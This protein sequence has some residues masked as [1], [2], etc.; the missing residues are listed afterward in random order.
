M[1]ADRSFVIQMSYQSSRVIAFVWHGDALICVISRVYNFIII[2]RF[3]TLFF[4]NTAHNNLHIRMSG[5]NMKYVFLKQT[6]IAV[7]G[8]WH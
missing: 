1:F 4:S 5:D 7:S 3:C 8:W 2:D 6:M